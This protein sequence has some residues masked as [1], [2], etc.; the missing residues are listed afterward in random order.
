[1]HS[2]ERLNSGTQTRESVQKSLER[3][4]ATDRCI[5]W[6]RHVQ[7]RRT[8]EI[9][10]LLGVSPSVASVRIHRATKR[11]KRILEEGRKAA[12]SSRAD[13]QARLTELKSA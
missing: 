7:E 4:S 5:L 12:D 11:L 10:R 13:A 6:M 9:A 1:M 8:A 2:D 3:L